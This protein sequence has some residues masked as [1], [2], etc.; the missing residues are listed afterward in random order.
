MAETDI[1]GKRLKLPY[2]VERRAYEIDQA[3]PIFASLR[4]DYAGFDTW[5]EKCKRQ[6][7]TAGSWKLKMKSP[8]CIR[9]V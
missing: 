9:K 2:V 8:D 3:H 1:H 4:T 7:G 5:F 6:Q